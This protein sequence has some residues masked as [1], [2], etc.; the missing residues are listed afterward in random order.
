MRALIALFVLV[1][2]ASSSPTYMP[3]GKQGYA[4]NCSGAAR[5][6][7]M[8]FEKAGELCG[9]KGYEVVGRDGEPLAAVGGSYQ[10]FAGAASF[11]RSMLVKC[12]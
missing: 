11:S 4:L 7:G 12:K 1:G 8:C 9:S 5:N 10:G 3:D 2:C 6:W